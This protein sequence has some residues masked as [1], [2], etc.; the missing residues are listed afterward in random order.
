MA[1]TTETTSYFERILQSLQA[2]V[3]RPYTPAFRIEE[4]TW[5]WRIFDGDTSIAE[6]SAKA[7]LSFDIWKFSPFEPEIVV[8]E[9]NNSSVY[10]L[11]T[12]RNTLVNMPIDRCGDVA[13]GMEDAL[14]CMQVDWVQAG[15]P[16]LI[17]RVTGNFLQGQRM[18]YTARFTYDAAQARYRFFFDAEAWK[19]TRWGGEP[20]NMMMVN[21]LVDTPEKV[22]WT[23]SIWEDP[24]GRLKQIV[25]S[26]ALFSVADYGDSDG[27]WRSKNAPLQGA[28]IAYAANPVFNPA[29]LVHE[30]NAPVYFATCSQLFDEHLIWQDAGLDELDEGY[31]HFVMR[32]EFIN[33]P[34]ALAEEF[35]AQAAPPPCPTQWRKQMVALAFKMNQVNDF[36]EAVDV[37]E[38]EDCPVFALDKDLW[39]DDEGHSGTHSI[40]LTGACFHRW[41]TAMPTG[42]VC[43]VE[44]FSRYRL[45][46]WIKTAGVGRFARLQL[47]SYEYTYTNFIDHARSAHV[48]G[49]SDW[50]YVEAEL[51]SNDEAYVMPVIALYGEGAAWFDDL[52]LEKI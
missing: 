44:P 38:P 12:M 37:W 16:E 4:S 11:Y 5:G 31:F 34:A 39:V 33:M 35:L 49:D 24:W 45:S 6:F 29:M 43:T 40:R 50:T 51:D 52:K 3:P 27:Q 1:T 18:V 22:R 46:G 19:L 47:S 21:A 7:G 9:V 36:E 23:H 14:S 2:P 13:E 42:A 32:T 30:T 41:Q 26:N 15:G 8:N 28:W 48:T 20:L 25:H 17:V 10:D